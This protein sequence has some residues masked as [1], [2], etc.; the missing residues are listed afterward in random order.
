MPRILRHLQSSSSSIH[1]NPKLHDA[2]SSSDDENDDDLRLEEEEQERLLSEKHGET[3]ELSASSKKRSGAGIG[4]TDTDIAN[5]LLAHKKK[6]TRLTLTE[7][8]LLGSKGLLSIRHG[9]H[10]KI[11]YPKPMKVTNGNNKSMNDRSLMEIKDST[12]YL[13]KLMKNYRNFAINLMP[14]WTPKETFLKIQDM[15]SKREVKAYVQIMRDEVCKEYLGGTMGKDEVELLLDEL[16]CGINAHKNQ[17]DLADESNAFDDEEQQVLDK[18]RTMSDSVNIV[19]DNNK[20]KDN[21]KHND[22]DNSGE[23]ESVSSHELEISNPEQANAEL[24]MEGEVTATISDE[25][26][27]LRDVA[28]STDNDVVVSTKLSV[29]NKS[30]SDINDESINDHVTNVSGSNK[31]EVVQPLDQNMNPVVISDD[32]NQDETIIR[33]ND[34]DKSTTSCKNEGQQKHEQEDSKIYMND[35]MITTEDEFHES[36]DETILTGGMKLQSECNSQEELVRDGTQ[37]NESPIQMNESP[38]Q[39]DEY[40]SQTKE[41]PTQTSEEVPMEVVNQM[42]EF[43]TQIN[44]SSTQIDESPTQNNESPTQ[45]DE[46]PT[47]ITQIDNSSSQI[48]E[49]PTQIAQINDSQTQNDESPTQ[50]A[51]FSIN[52]EFSEGHLV[53][54]MSQQFEEKDTFG[55]T[56]LDPSSLCSLD[57]DE[58]EVGISQDY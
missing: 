35:K 51:T 54:D 23:N 12:C 49:S 27:Q 39:I 24:E 11:K 56:P 3:S 17:N 55:S 2:F 36:K 28:V 7:K 44:E 25:E 46:S 40:Q 50:I 34:E 20:V 16:Q 58:E 13:N 21:L 37:I 30:L 14:S 42:D 29:E 5:A 57:R 18:D 41:S 33:C 1:S 22:V 52:E 48:H 10:K 8:E 31:H 47:Q 53:E 15:G 32:I 26:E 19:K 43:S 45:L 9:F 4:E 38:T 6:K